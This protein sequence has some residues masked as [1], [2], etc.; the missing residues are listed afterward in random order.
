MT[1]PR[2]C[3]FFPRVLSLLTGRASRSAGYGN[4]RRGDLPGVLV[5]VSPDVDRVNRRGP[6]REPIDGRD[7]DQ[8]A[9]TPRGDDTFGGFPGQ[10]GAALD[11]RTPQARRLL[12][13]RQLPLGRADL[14]AR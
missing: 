10:G 13:G 1:C 14:P 3:H 9:S 12:A 6:A 5:G 4:D 11:G 8:D 2:N 7:A